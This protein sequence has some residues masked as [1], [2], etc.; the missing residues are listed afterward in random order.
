MP[1][2]RCEITSHAQETER[3]LPLGHHIFIQEKGVQKVSFYLILVPDPAKNSKYELQY[4]N[5]IQA[6][7]NY[8]CNRNI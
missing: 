4:N 5:N 2:E 7:F 3:A 1:Q 8:S 6:K